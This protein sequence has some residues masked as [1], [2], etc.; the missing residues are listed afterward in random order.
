M[1]VMVFLVSMMSPLTI[2]NEPVEAHYD[3][4][5]D[6]PLRV[7]VYINKLYSTEDYD[8]SVPYLEWLFGG[9]TEIVWV[10]QLKHDYHDSTNTIYTF[11]WNMDGEGWMEIHPEEVVVD[12]R[13][14]YELDMGH[15][16]IYNHIECTDREKLTYSYKI[17]EDDAE[18][19]RRV[20]EALIGFGET[21]SSLVLIGGGTVGTIA[22]GG[23]AG[24]VTVMGVITG[25]VGVYDGVKRMINSG[26][27][28]EFNDEIIGLN[29]GQELSEDN[30]G[31]NYVW[32]HTFNEQVGAGGEF[33]S[34]PGMGVELE[35]VV[36]PFEVVG[37]GWQS[38]AEGQS[39]C[40]QPA[41]IA[42]SQEVAALDYNEI[43]TDVHNSFDSIRTAYI[44]INESTRLSGS[45]N[46]IG[47]DGCDQVNGTGDCDDWNNS[48]KPPVDPLNNTDPYN[49]T[50]HTVA[51]GLIMT[52]GNGILGNI[53]GDILAS[54]NAVNPDATYSISMDLWYADFLT[55]GGHY[56]DALG[57]Y[58]SAIIGSIDAIENAPPPPPATITIQAEG[59]NVPE[60]LF[61]EI[62]SGDCGDDCAEEDLVFVGE[63][64]DSVIETTLESGEYTVVMIADGDVYSS[65]Y[66][67]VQSGG[68]ITV[69]MTD[70]GI[71]NTALNLAFYIQG[72]IVAA[73]PALI[74]FTGSRQYLEREDE[75]SES[76]LEPSTTP[77]WIGLVTFIAIFFMMIG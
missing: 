48:Q 76:K 24:P 44:G 55:K 31:I 65:D 71:D 4:T 21:V 25:G 12:G 46:P 59:D 61:I 9:A 13:T 64:G 1:I 50:T 47:S 29:N 35:L 63:E 8:D 75:S 16:E 74:G 43:R 6:P 67:E 77:L 60:D 34:T 73:L 39:S 30:N 7:Q 70:G 53:T 32:P 20:T 10:S 41:P 54:A 42:P 37:P 52:E 33:Q 36:T 23:L 40:I 19:A 3:E 49:S 45:T 17:R 72:L 14:V 18:G 57:Y 2:D 66:L 22:T 26:T 58:E 28:A 62:Y 51:R 68:D 15:M 69:L 27:G 38:D 11:S 56:F 5:T